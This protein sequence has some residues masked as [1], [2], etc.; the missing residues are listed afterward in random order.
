M[1]SV[2][3][4]SNVSRTASVATCSGFTFSPV[5]I[6]TAAVL[7]VLAVLAALQSLP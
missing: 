3:F 6:A 2:V 5:I 7:A 1:S 4:L